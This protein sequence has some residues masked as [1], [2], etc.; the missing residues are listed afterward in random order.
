MGGVSTRLADYGYGPVAGFYDELAGFY[1][2]GRI[3]L[4]KA[5]HLAHLRPGDRV[6]YPGV[7][8]G[9][10]AIEAARRGACVTAIDISPAMLRRLQTAFAAE[11]LEAESIEGDVSRHRPIEPY[12]VV[13]A[14]Y[15]L[16]LFEA[17]R[18]EAMLAHL[19]RCLRPGG[20]LVLTDFA[21][22]VGGLRGRLASEIYY[23]PVN[24]I[25]WLLGLCALHPILD[26]RPMLA[27]GEWEIVGEERH[28]VFAG[29]NPAFVSIVARR[30]AD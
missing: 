28:T 29:P 18:A 10:E 3:P 7:G 15:F 26:Y 17:A 6:L 8:R 20:L 9:R 14:N 16:N 27:A 2:R 21:R 1:S 24:W 25:A 30:R 22:P 4:T 11:G 12:D 5:A 13:V 19:A 23:R